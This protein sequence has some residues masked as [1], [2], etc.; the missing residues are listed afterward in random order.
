MPFAPNARF[1]FWILCVVFLAAQPFLWAQ[2]PN[3]ARLY[4]GMKLEELLG[5]FG[6]PQSVYAARGQEPWQDDV[7][8]TYSEGDFYVFKDRVWQVSV[9][10]ACGVSVGE[11]KQAA[12]LALG[13]EAA[14]LGD[15]LFLPLPDSGWPLALRVNLNTSGKVSAIFIYRPDY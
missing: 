3:D 10:T 2:S 15:H 13:E 12:L 4:V 7:V 1:C 5:K 9:K 14:D 11:P 8:F 6:T